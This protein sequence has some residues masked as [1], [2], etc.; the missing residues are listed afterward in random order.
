MLSVMRDAAVCI[1]F[2][3]RWAYR[4][5]VCTWVWPRSLPIMVRLSPSA[6]A[7]L[8]KLVELALLD[9]ILHVAAGAVE[10][11]VEVLRGD[12]V[13]RQQRGDEAGVGAGA[14]VRHPFRLGDQLD[15]IGDIVMRR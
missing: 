4:A 14:A 7:L 9:A 8:A 3:A 12:L 11:F 6:S 5:V 15:A 1:E 13:G 10:A 2:C